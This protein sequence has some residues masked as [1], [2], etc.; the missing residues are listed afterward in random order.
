MVSESSFA[1]SAADAV[2][3]HMDRPESRMV[4]TAM[5]RFEGRV[6]LETL[7]DVI[8]DRLVAVYPR[9]SRRVVEPRLGV[10]PPRWEPDPGFELDA[11]V[12]VE[13]LEAP[14]DELALQRFCGEVLSRPLDERRPPWQ[15]HVVTLAAPS[16]ATALVVRIHHAVADGISLARVILDLADGGVPAV[17]PPPARGPSPFYRPLLT[18]MHAGLRAGEHLW[19]EAL[20]LA[21]HPERLLRHART[22]VDLAAAASHLLLMP[23]DPPTVLRG[24]LGEAKRVAWCAPQRLETIKVT[25][26]A[27]GI[28]VND[29]LL[30]AMAGAMRR[31]L[32]DR[33]SP[34]ADIR[35]FVPVN[36]R[37]I[38][39]RVPTELGNHFSLAVLT[40]P[41]AEATPLGRVEALKRN[42]DAIK[43]S[44]E[45]AVAYAILNTMG[46][47]PPAIEGALLSF[48]G[49]KASAVMTNVPGPREHVSFAGHRVARIMF[50]VPMSA[51]VGLGVSIL[52]YAGEVMVGIA[53]DAGL[54]PDPGRLA[55]LWEGELELLH[56][57]A[58]ARS[59]T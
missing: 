19:R 3:L 39:K 9:F 32:E 52:S 31:Y 53:S 25:C 12:V 28:T 50:W 43:H 11:H 7:R 21:A 49:T 18:A 8:R 41:V 33:G 46:M 29:A 14:A 26:R 35:A 23:P 59:P 47:T 40:L 54:V 36:L 1:M 38:D 44:E 2:W 37:P 16:P 20:D 22:G 56:A 27:L 4:V 58:G 55:A 51:G 42:M 45:P 48:F 6:P 57:L 30:A 24:P 34:L 17:T 15:A 5:L 10:G 13:E